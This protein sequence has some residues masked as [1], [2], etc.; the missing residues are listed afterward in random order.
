MS[1][2][3]DWNAIRARLDTTRGREFWRSLDEL[4]EHPD[5]LEYLQQEFP[6]Q[7]NP[8]V[9]SGLDRRVFMKLMAASLGL[10]G[11]NACTR[12]PEEK[13][14]PYV[15]QPEQLV[16]GTPLSYATA[17]PFDGGSIGLLVESHEGRPTKIEGNPL[18]P[19]S[20]GATDAI[21]QAAILTLYDP[22]RSQV[23]TSAGTIRP[24]SAFRTV[25]GN[26][27]AAQRP[28]QGA[29]L[30]F[31]TETVTSPTLAAQMESLLRELP[32]AQ[33]HQWEPSARDGALEGARRA[34]G[35]V[36]DTHYRLDRADIIVSLDAD[37]FTVGPQRLRLTREFV[38]RRRPD[39]KTMNR[40]YVIESTPSLTGAK[41]DHRL[42]VRAGE[43][44]S[45]ARALAI[46]V[47][48]KIE[49]G[50]GSAAAP[51]GN[52]LSHLAADLRDHKGRSAIIVGDGQPAPVHAL[53]HAL[54]VALGN[55]GQTV[56]YTEPAAFRPTEPAASLRALVD[57]MQA[58]K[59]ECLVILGANPVATAP[60][61][62]QFGAALAKVG[63]RIH[64]GLFHDE[65]AEQCHWHVPDTHFLESWS[66]TRAYDGTAS[67][68]Q[69]L[70]APL[71]EGRSAHEFL[72]AFSAAPDRTAF[73][74]VRA[75]WAAVHSGPDFDTFWQRSLH[76][77]VIAGATA[78]PKT[79][80]LDRGFDSGPS[81]AATTGIELIFRLD[82]NV[83]DGRFANNGW[84]QELPRPM[85]KLVW[86]NA[87]LLA[88]AT[89]ARLGI[90]QGDV[91]EI[92][93]D[94]Q[95]LR[96]PA[97]LSPGHAAE[98]VTLTL[99]YGRQRAGRVGTG[100]G[101]DVNGLRSSR[102]LHFAQGATIRTTTERATLATTQDHHAMEGRAPVR[103][104]T[105]AEFVSTP[106]FAKHAEEQPGDDLTLYPPYA[107]TGH[108]WGMTIDLGACIGCNACTIACQA[109]NNIPVVGKD[110]VLR[111]RE[112]HWIRVDR[113]YTGDI[114]RPDTVHQPVPCMHCEN[115]PC[116]LVC[117][118][119]ATVH[120]SE[121]LNDMVYNRCVGTRYCSNNCPYKVRRYNFF[122]YSDWTTKSLALA[123]NPDVTVRSRG[124]MEKCSYCVQRIERARVT[125]HQSDTTIRDGDIVTACQQACPAEA[126][127][128]GDVNDPQS[129]VTKLKNDPRNYLLLAS[130][131]T[132]PRTSYL[133]AVR[134]PNTAI[135]SPELDKSTE[136]PHS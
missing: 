68:I 74:M 88:P 109:E 62:L 85:S 38:R 115:A 47:G 71:Y 5:F 86:D 64:H 61:D 105:L 128:F 81:P 97:W 130:L 32:A 125:A 79:P 126:I 92:E 25:A 16:L 53:A 12:Q 122:L 8:A 59:V 102:A 84:L 65:T 18:H 36:V 69:P 106:D 50:D 104:A 57:D 3:A 127:V 1:H 27:L 10:A 89:A 121:G 45:L 21:T 76:D 51:H 78:A 87:A 112:M 103:I 94:G 96:L 129:R 48:T 34:F 113:Y 135:E 56:I 35:E 30:R 114:D 31:L 70:I 11:L 60:G 110:L 46:A 52:W 37:F 100:V 66:D 9:E 49:A 13:I 2:H 99:G 63:L 23:V 14:V 117:P 119:N 54:N 58:G 19:A 67:I 136:G 111:G 120:S 91:I 39:A 108:A 101:I 90:A 93:R 82:A 33:W 131:N 133:A 95:R 83:H 26:M 28:R 15:H 116:E 77:G 22:D 98:A 42:A 40:L 132:R 123:R 43:V 118:V 7:T 17:M 24:W 134:N 107:Y 73:E 55:V 20:L 124:V 29:G 4:A 6:R 80:T 44:E 41:A 72:A 75:T